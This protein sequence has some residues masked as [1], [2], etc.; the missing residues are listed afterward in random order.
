MPVDLVVN[1]VLSYFWMPASF[2]F[3]WKDLLTNIQSLSLW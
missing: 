1:I 2:L 3:V